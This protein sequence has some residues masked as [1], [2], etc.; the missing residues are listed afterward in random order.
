[1]FGNLAEM[2]GMLKKAKEIKGNM[3]AMKS[4]MANTE[5]SG[6]AAGGKVIA[7]VSGD[8]T[9]RRITIDPNLDESN[10]VLA[11]IVTAAVNDAINN[12]RILLQQKMKDV[13]GG[14]DIPDIF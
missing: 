12:T 4:E 2:A 10:E 6:T 13:T 9:V 11:Q 5:V 14:L 1:M 3:Q 8:F 7:I